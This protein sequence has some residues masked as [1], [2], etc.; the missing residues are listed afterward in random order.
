MT[1]FYVDLTIA[2]IT[3]SFFYFE[4][5]IIKE[6]KIGMVILILTG[7]VGL[8]FDVLLASPLLFNLQVLIPLK[9]EVFQK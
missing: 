2:S 3:I 8:L 5:G 6:P 4:L 7:V 9:D 1:V